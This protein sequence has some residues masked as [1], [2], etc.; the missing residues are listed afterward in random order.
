[1]GTEDVGG[2]IL[3]KS[4]ADNSSILWHQKKAPC[5]SEA[6]ANLALNLLKEIT[7]TEEQEICGQ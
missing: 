6:Q 2:G 5:F 1:M 7:R 3:R 4:G